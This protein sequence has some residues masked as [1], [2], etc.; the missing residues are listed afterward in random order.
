MRILLLLSGCL[1]LT[2]CGSSPSVQS[3]N[4]GAY[5]VSFSHIPDPLQVGSEAQLEVRVADKQGRELRECTTGF[6][7]YMPGM[8]MELD[9]TEINLPINANGAYQ[10]T[11]KQFSMGGDWVLEVTINCGDG[12]VSHAFEYTLQWPE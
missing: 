2:A 12:P 3:V 7:Q 6:R 1:W 11:S 5:T 10:G 8:E 9:R 4:M